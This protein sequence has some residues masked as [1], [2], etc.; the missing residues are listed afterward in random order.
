MELFRSAD[1]SPALF[2]LQRAFFYSSMLSFYAIMAH[3]ILRFPFA[4]AGAV[5]LLMVSSGSI[6]QVIAGKFSDRWGRRRIAFLGQAT[7]GLGLI[8]MGYAFLHLYIF[9]SILGFLLTGIGGNSVQSSINAVVADISASGRSMIGNFA[10]IRTAINSGF[11][12]GPMLMGLILGLNWLNYG[13]VL[14][15]MGIVSLV[16]LLF[17]PVIQGKE[18][19]RP[20]MNYA[21][22]MNLNP[23]YLIELSLSAFLISM[24][25]GQLTSSVPVYEELVNHLT[26]GNVGILLGLNGFVIVLIQYPISKLVKNTLNWKWMTGGSVIYSFSVF[27]LSV[28]TAFYNTLIIVILITLGEAI[29][30]A[31]AQALITSL[32]N[33]TKYGGNLGIWAF[34]VNMGRATGAEYGLTVFTLLFVNHAIMWFIIAVPGLMSAMFFGVIINRINKDIRKDSVPILL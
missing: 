15:L 25:F 8:L 19:A 16:F 6:F 31:T 23:R 18:T 5:M 21:K 10:K 20:M 28:A 13:V 3:Q 33:P 12:L 14:E 32:S 9:P 26:L 4:S 22:Y 11:G 7:Q 1:L 24:V 34:G 29:F 17:I 27:M 30:W 2:S